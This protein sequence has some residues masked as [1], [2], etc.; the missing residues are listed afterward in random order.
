MNQEDD[1]SVHSELKVP[2]DSDDYEEVVFLKGVYLETTATLK[3]LRN[4]FIDSNQLDPNHL[5]FQFLRSDTLGDIV[6]IDNEEETKPLSFDSKQRT[7]YVQAI[8]RSMALNIFI[9]I[10]G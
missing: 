4:S 7:I 10:G 2:V 6:P 9:T 5:Y 8:D 1:S 3:D